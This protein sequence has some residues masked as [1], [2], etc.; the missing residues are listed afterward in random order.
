MTAT[1]AQV[2]ACGGYQII[3]ADPPWSY[4]DSGCIGAA[5]KEYETMDTRSIADLPIGDIAAK[6]AVMFMWGTYPK[7]ADLLEL[8]PRW[9]FTYKSIAFQWVKTKGK[10]P[11][12]TDKAFF[13]LGRW[14]RGNTEPCFLATRGKP[15]RLSASVS[16]LVTT[17]DEDLVIAPVGRHSAKPPEVRDRIVKLMGDLPRIELFARERTPGWD[18]WGNDPELGAPDVIL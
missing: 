7:I 2:Q 10:H 14:T 17:L 16:Q 12:G 4:N 11:D 13:G 3:Y 18:V 8:I 9:G 5:A 6:D 1:I 15:T